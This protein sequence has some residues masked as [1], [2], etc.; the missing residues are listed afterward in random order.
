MEKKRNK[1][2]KK[3]RTSR[4]KL[5]FYEK[6]VYDLTQLL[7]ISKSLCAVLEHS[8]LIE[9]I[10]YTC[11]CQMR[12]L[13]AGMFVSQDYGSD[14]L[15]L[16]NFYSGLEPDTFI[17]YTV[18]TRQPQI[19]YLLE[20]NVPM[21]LTALQ[22]KF[23]GVPEI[24]P[25][26]SLHPSLV[27]PLKHKN[28][29][30]GILLLG[31][32]IDL[33]DGVK[34]SKYEIDQ[35]KTIATLAAIAVYNA[36]LMELTTTDMLTKLKL[37]HYFFTVLSDKYDIAVAQK[38]PIAVLMLDID[39]FK[40]F[41]DTYGHACGDYVLKEVA[42][43]ISDGIRAHDM[44]GRYGGEEFIIMLTNTETAAA[45]MVAER[46]RS[47]IEKFDFEYENNHMNVTIS[48]GVS[49]LHHDE[50]V[51]AKTLVEQADQALYTSKRLGR[52]KVSLFTT[53]N[54]DA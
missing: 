11:M 52:N 18:S 25:F 51:T 38:Q 44:A 39:L 16:R 48:I 37:R 35:I 17:S 31:E 28:K 2:A 9:S 53:E 23:K 6:R 50:P 42:G 21:T 20:K 8:T 19:Q 40:K 54:S 1:P 47:N 22:R 15:E 33:G 43:I 45:V 46:I 30:S 34:F 36:S 13:G 4:E 7:E 27:I 14:T 29:L 26:K 32:R 10:L 5:K 41:N 49:V 24:I 12:V 3:R